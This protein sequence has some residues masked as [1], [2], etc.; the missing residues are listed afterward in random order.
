[1][2]AKRRSSI[3][4]A[5]V[6]STRKLMEALGEGRAALRSRQARSTPGVACDGSGCAMPNESLASW[7]GWR[8][9]SP[10]VAALLVAAVLSGACTSVSPQEVRFTTSPDSVGACRFV[11]IVESN[12]ADALPAAKD[13]LRDE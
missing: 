2:T 9:R 13:A 10:L 8:R 5:A 3:G 11:T 6:S 1:M 4:T 12:G 7:D